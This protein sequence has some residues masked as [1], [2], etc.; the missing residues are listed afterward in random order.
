MD[1]DLSAQERRRTVLLDV[2]RRQQVHSQGDLVK[3]MVSK[4]VAVDQA[5]LSRDL[6][7][8]GV[9]KGS[10]GYEPPASMDVDRAARKRLATLLKDHLMGI[11]SAGLILV[12]RITPGYA[13]PVAIE[14]DQVGFSGLVGSIAGRDTVFLAC[15]GESEHRRL[16]SEIAKLS[17]RSDLRP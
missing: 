11:G 8:M 2:L 9:T 13:G 3:I 6:R 5:T 10:S 4:G 12:L 17:S 7:S 14:I 1:S 16:H 15:E